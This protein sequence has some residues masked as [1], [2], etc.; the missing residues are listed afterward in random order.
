MR[1]CC[2]SSR[3]SFS[4]IASFWKTRFPHLLPLSAGMEIPTRADATS[5]AY[6]RWLK[7]PW[8]DSGAPAKDSRR[9]TALM[10][11]Y[12]HV[13][14]SDCYKLRLMFGLLGM[15]YERRPVDMY[16]GHADQ[17]P[18]FRA[19]SPFGRLPVLQDGNLTIWDAQRRSCTLQ[20]VATPPF[21]LD[22]PKRG[23]TRKHPDMASGGWWAVA[24]CRRRAG[25]QS[26]WRCVFRGMVLLDVITIIDDRIIEQEN[27]WIPN[28][29][30]SDRPTI[31]DQ[32]QCFRTSLFMKMRGSLWTPILR[33]APLAGGLRGAARLWLR[34]PGSRLCNSTH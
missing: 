1:A 3:R 22:G 28:G 20:N 30:L 33:T 2:S 21:V 24:C 23:R 11:L 16:P 19:L 9:V 18:A 14:S 10:I 27:S 7:K 31:A 8:C 13:L 12:D 6:R 34:C 25:S 17:K 4:K 26:V 29:W 15:D 5:I 32:S